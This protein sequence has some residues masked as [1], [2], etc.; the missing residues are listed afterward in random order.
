[1][2]RC[3]RFVKWVLVEA[4]GPILPM[5]GNAAEERGLWWETVPRGV[6][7]WVWCTVL[8]YKNDIDKKEF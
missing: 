4:G 7:N 2:R 3:R 6:R 8:E 5:P 1:M